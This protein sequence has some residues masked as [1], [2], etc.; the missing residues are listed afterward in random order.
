MANPHA[1]NVY[2]SVSPD[3][4]DCAPKYMRFCRQ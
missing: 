3:H 4:G 2:L 1:L